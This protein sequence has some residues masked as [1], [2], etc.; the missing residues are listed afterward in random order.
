MPSQVSSSASSVISLSSRSSAKLVKRNK[1][2]VRSRLLN[3]LGIFNGPVTTCSSLNPAEARKTSMLRGMGLGGVILPLNHSTSVPLTSLHD[4]EVKSRLFNA[5]AT[6]EPLKYKNDKKKYKPVTQRHRKISFDDSVAVMPI[7]MR[8]EYSD[9]VRSRLWNN[10][11][12]IHENATRNAMEFAA[13]GWD[14]RSVTEDDGMFVCTV[15]GELVHPVHCQQYYQYANQPEDP[16]I[17][18]APESGPVPTSV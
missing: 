7:P 2:E 17:T 14:W 11:Y 3:R 5:V 8:T 1:D 13:E 15:S 16:I 18:S 4:T 9:R 10:R 6:S 12:E